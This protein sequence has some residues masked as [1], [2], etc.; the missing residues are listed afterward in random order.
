MLTGRVHSIETLGALDGPG[1]RTVVFLSGCPL[2][3]AYCHNPDTWELGNGKEMTAL[4][5]AQKVK[6]Y[7]PYFKEHGGVTLSGGEPLF[8]C[9]F[10][11][12]ILK[13]CK[14]QGIK[15]ALDTSGA[16]FSQSVKG[17]LPYVDLVILD[18]KHTDPAAFF[19]LTGQPMDTTLAFLEYC[20]HIHIPIWIRQVIVPTITDNEKNI[21]ALKELAKGA[22]LQKIELLPYHKQGIYKWDNL[23][24]PYSLRKISEPSVELMNYY[25]KFISEK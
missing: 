14:E 9:A 15:T 11:T 22:N 1:L 7:K 21:L 17:L 19:K 24:I 5:V 3:C 8:Q 4:E 13:L 10:A 16:V 20:K 18:I 6:R 25:K 2:R 23:G 12:E